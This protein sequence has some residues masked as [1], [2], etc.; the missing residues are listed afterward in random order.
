MISP[1]SFFPFLTRYRIRFQRETRFRSGRCRMCDIR[2]MYPLDGLSPTVSAHRSLC[3]DCP[4]LKSTD[5]SHHHPH[6]DTP[7]LLSYWSPRRKDST[8]HLPR[9]RSTLPDFHP[10]SRWSATFPRCTYRPGS[11]RSHSGDSGLFWLPE[12]DPVHSAPARCR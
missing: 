1:L 3:P 7:A 2:R 8:P 4:V 5:N 6:P 9:A 11:S 12:T 10:S